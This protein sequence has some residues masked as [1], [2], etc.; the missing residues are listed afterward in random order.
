MLDRLPLSVAEAVLEWVVALEQDAADERL[1]DADRPLLTLP[2]RRLLRFATLSR[3]WHELVDRVVLA[4]IEPNDDLIDRLDA[5]PALWR[6]V[7]AVMINFG[8]NEALGGLPDE[9]RD[10]G[11]CVA[12]ALR[13]ARNAE[14]LAIE[15]T[16]GDVELVYGHIMAGWRAVILCV[17]DSHDDEVVPYERTDVSSVIRRVIDKLAPTLESLD[18]SLAWADTK[19]VPAEQVFEWPQM[20]RLDVLKVRIDLLHDF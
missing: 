5:Q 7:K 12:A 6:R 14:L 10:R 9:Y 19:M 2:R 1:T 13:S 15:G 16:A 20:P 4:C 3:Q 11:R 8:R 18:I 17:F